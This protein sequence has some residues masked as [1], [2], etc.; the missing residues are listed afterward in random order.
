ML[1]TTIFAMASL[2]LV[3]SAL[4]QDPNIKH[5]AKD[6]LSFDYPSNWQIT[7][8]S[9][10]QMQF[11]ELTQGDVV[12]RVR[13]PREWL[14]TPEK[15][16]QAKK[17]FQDKYVDEFEAQLEHASLHPKRSAVT[18]QIAGADAEGVRI[19]A[20]LDGEPGGMDSYY[21]VISDRLV[22][23][24]IFASDKDIARIA[25]GW[26]VLRNSLKVEPPPQPKSTP[27]PSPA[28]GKP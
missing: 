15:E 14:K 2:L 1:R 10:G 26:D 4:A 20:V 16:A 18:T 23:L 19:R 27:R 12:I 6:G 21:R 3:I 24:S 9:S 28:K 5:F 7:D 22:N 8:Q 17:L 25:P 13:S 11:F